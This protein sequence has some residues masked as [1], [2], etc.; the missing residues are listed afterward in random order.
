MP[1]CVRCSKPRGVGD[2]VCSA[3]VIRIA[4]VNRSPVRS[5]RYKGRYSQ[6][7][8]AFLVISFTSLGYLGGQAVSTSATWWARF[9]MLYYFLFPGDALG[10]R[11]ECAK[12]PP[13]D[14]RAVS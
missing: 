1:C 4:M 13:E 5:M 12:R 14:L 10:L 11:Y 2:E 8:L 3:C 9:F 7:A 6:C